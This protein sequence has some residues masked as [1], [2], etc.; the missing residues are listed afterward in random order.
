MYY[1]ISFVCSFSCNDIAMIPKSNTLNPC[2]Q[3]QAKKNG[4][5]IMVGE[6]EMENG[7]TDKKAYHQRWTNYIGQ[8]FPQKKRPC[9]IHFSMPFFSGPITRKIN[10]A[11]RRRARKDETS[12]ILFGI[13]F[14]YLA[15]SFPFILFILQNSPK[16]TVANCMVIFHS[17]IIATFDPY[18]QSSEPV[19]C[20]YSS[21][22]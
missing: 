5:K 7:R 16:I 22:S 8:V 19:Q 2:N 20:G 4:W 11:T 1:I 17:N 21:S 10:D 15:F 12:K 6:R 3:W 13:D 18:G 9:S 14:S